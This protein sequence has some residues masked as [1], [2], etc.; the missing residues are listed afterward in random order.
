MA[1]CDDAP[2]GQVSAWRGTGSSWKLAP[3]PAPRYPRVLGGPKGLS[4]WKCLQA[5]PCPLNPSSSGPAAAK[6]QPKE[7]NHKSRKGAVIGGSP[8][9]S[10]TDRPGFVALRVLKTYSFEVEA[11]REEGSVEGAQGQALWVEMSVAGMSCGSTECSS[12]LSLLGI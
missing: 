5:F 6:A 4:L 12:V 11:E 1:R 3:S 2:L 8:R 10:N 9:P 7:K